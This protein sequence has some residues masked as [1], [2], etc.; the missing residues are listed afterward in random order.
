MIR[1]PIRNEVRVAGFSEPETRN[2]ALVLK[3][4]SL[5][6]RLEV[7]SQQALK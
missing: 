7:V 4:G 5:P 3:T 6:V 2:L 1:E